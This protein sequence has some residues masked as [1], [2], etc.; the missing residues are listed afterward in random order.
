MGSRCTLRAEFGISGDCALKYSR[1]PLPD[2]PK[3][4]ERVNK[5]KGHLVFLKEG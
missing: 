2:N 4:V 5:D 3:S 1:N